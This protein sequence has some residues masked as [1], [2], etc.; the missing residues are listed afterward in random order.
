MTKFG[1]AKKEN[2]PVFAPT[3]TRA[4]VQTTNERKVGKKPGS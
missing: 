2:A 3:K 1:D 4:D